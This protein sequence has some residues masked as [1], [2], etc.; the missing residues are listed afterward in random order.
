MVAPHSPSSSSTGVEPLDVRLPRTLGWIVVALVIWASRLQLPQPTARPDLDP[1][2]QQGLAVALANGMQFG[3]DLIFTFGPLGALSLGR[4]QPELF[5][6][7][8][9]L[10]E[11]LFKGL[12]AWRWAEALRRWPSGLDRVV[13]LLFLIAS[14][15]GMDAFYF[16]TITIL[17]APH[18]EDPPKSRAR[19][20]VDCVLL[21]AIGFIK[22][23]YSILVVGAVAMFTVRAW[24]R[25]RREAL[26]VAGTYAAAVV[27]V[28]CAC[29][30]APWNLPIFYLRSLAI[31]GGYSEAQ[32]EDGDIVEVWIGLAWISCAFLLSVATVWWTSRR[33]ERTVAALIVLLGAYVAFKASFTFHRAHGIT[34]FG[35]ASLAL[36]ALLPAADTSVGR[37]IALGVGRGIAAL[38][39]LAGLSTLYETSP[40]M[41]GL[42][43]GHA[44]QDLLN[45]GRGL[46][47]IPVLRERLEQ[48]RRVLAAEAALPRLQAVI[49]SA[50]VDLLSSSQG[51]IFLNDLAWKPRPVF[52]SYL[53][54]APSLIEMNQ[55]AFERPDAAEFVL[56]EL[57]SISSRLGGMEDNGA[58]RALLHGYAPVTQERGIALLKRDPELASRPPPTYTLLEEREVAPGETVRL[59]EHLGEMLRV[60]FDVG[61]SLLGTLRRI[62]YH[63]PITRIHLELEGGA[64]LDCRLLPG[65]ASSGVMLRPYVEGTGDWLRMYTRGLDK[66]VAAFSVIS[67]DDWDSFY[68]PRYRVAI[69]R[70]DGLLP[71]PDK[72]REPKYAFASFGTLPTQVSAIVEPHNYMVAGREVALVA[73]N[74]HIAFDLEPGEHRLR[75]GFGLLEASRRGSDGV[76][77]TV[78]LV[79]RDAA[80]RVLLER[81]LDPRSAPELVV[82]IDLGFVSKDGDRLLLSTECP[83][84]R[85]QA[86]DLPF[87]EG[88]RIE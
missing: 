38:V 48:K 12:L 5:W 1:S 39:C 20:A 19:F 42:T 55:R 50:E 60:R 47:S 15:I 18:A 27:A 40:Q 52:Q 65:M 8:I 23:T 17:A 45:A 26:A 79:G 62:L 76:E 9:L 54:V 49:G 78:V 10:F 69:E 72:R 34:F 53:T 88:I 37:R 24:R 21:A 11:C 83:P 25:G 32:A 57:G 4:Y 66:K 28:W 6:V 71:K 31:A 59:D 64:K 86:M 56:L 43:L 35:Y 29:G 81:L 30:Q 84:G 7:H 2:W 14:A 63:A 22:F 70:V 51:R 13:F 67:A 73:N 61:Y 74:T 82:P 87:W 44:P 58:L 33:G 46:K 75:G 16:A 85:T 80:R 36:C 77:F 41:V 3:P 68:A